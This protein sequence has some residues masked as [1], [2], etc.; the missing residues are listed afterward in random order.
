MKIE[1]A[2]ITGGGSGGHVFPAIAIADEI[3]K[4][5]NNVKILFIGAEGKL[6]MEKVPAAGYNIEGLKIIGFKRKISFSHI[7]LP[8]K[9]F[10]SL[11]K[12]RKIIKK[13]KPQIVIGVGGYASGP[14]I[15]AAT[16]S[17]I[18]SIIQEQ[19]SFPG[20]TNK[21]LSK[22]TNKICVAYEGLE[23][24]FPKQKIIITGNPTR[25]N[26]VD[27]IG[28]KTDGYKFY[29]FDSTKKTILIIGGSLGAKTL[30]ESV[31]NKLEELKDSG[32]QVLWQCG[33]LYYKELNKKLK[34]ETLKNIKMVQFINR[35]DLAYSIA[36]VV[37]SR[38]GAIA[39][40]ELCLVKKATILV[41]S[42]NV[43]EDHQTK[44][45]M[46]LVKNKAAI[47][48]KDTIARK[49]LINRAL[50]LLDNKKESEELQNNI[51]KMGRPNATSDIVD[52]I[53]REI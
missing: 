7:L 22:K 49:I 34:I 50:E 19:N 44:N 25:K 47:L 38:A 13:F 16:I 15:L 45:A 17:K 48:I 35:M 12:A 42:P 28:K 30:N 23:S 18:P 5:N 8:F 2:I 14:T 46:A 37:I 41:P 31:I 32:V 52:I 27:I 9:I 40:S 26:M 4:R 53:E 11:I 33:K 43:S 51:S 21:I 6:E 10:Q 29:D 39:V 3:K 20:K 24:F 1:R 36:D